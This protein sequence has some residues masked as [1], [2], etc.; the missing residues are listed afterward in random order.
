[1]L[2]FVEAELKDDTK[3]IYQDYQIKLTSLLA[4]IE[5]GESTIAAQRIVSLGS[6][7]RHQ[8]VIE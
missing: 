4:G 8:R 1:L 6:S 7:K 3:I 2:G 5:S